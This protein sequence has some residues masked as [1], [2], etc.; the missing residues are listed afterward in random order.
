M[1]QPSVIPKE[2]RMNVHKNAR[3][4]PK[5]REAMVRAVMDDGE[6]VTA[7]AERFRTTRTTVDKWMKRFRKSGADGLHDRS[8]RPYSSP[9]QTAPTTCD[10]IAIALPDLIGLGC[11]RRGQ[12]VAACVARH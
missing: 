9:S 6:T 4:T 12:L 7:V 10:K 3:L 11:E 2:N 5:G 1:L 8:S